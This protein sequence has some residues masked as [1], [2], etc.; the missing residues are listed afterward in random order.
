MEG[1][2]QGP[3][4]LAEQTQLPCWVILISH[5]Q[6]WG[7][8]EERTCPSPPCFYIW[9]HQWCQIAKNPLHSQQWS[10]VTVS[11]Q[12]RQPPDWVHL[13]KSLRKAA[14]T[15]AC[16]KA[17]Y[18]QFPSAGAISHLQKQFHRHYCILYVLTFSAVLSSQYKEGL[19]LQ[20]W[21][22]PAKQS[23]HLHVTQPT[24]GSVFSEV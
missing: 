8:D 2:K 11:K 23:T 1:R 5:F 22:G 12:H 7:G 10:W 9:Y 13:Q 21:G 17:A 16:T 19:K 4:R 3:V 20:R 6:C 14:K 18:F 24:Q 15:R